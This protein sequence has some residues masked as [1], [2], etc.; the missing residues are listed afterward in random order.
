MKEAPIPARIREALEAKG[1][2]RG[3]FYRNV[4]ITSKSVWNWNRQNSIPLA[5]TAIKMAD[6]LSVSVKWLITGV[7]ES[8]LSPQEKILLDVFN[9]LNDTGKEAAIGA[10]RG[11]IPAF[12]SQIQDGESTKTAT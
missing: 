6:Y 3:D 7:D 8:G 11:L 12:P 9:K 10:V 1:L 4:G 2:K 5:D